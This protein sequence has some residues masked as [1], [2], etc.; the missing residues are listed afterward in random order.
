MEKY[1]CVQKNPNKYI[2]NCEDFNIVQKDGLIFSTNIKKINTSNISITYTSS[3][4]S[5]YKDYPHDELKI[6]FSGYVY[7]LVSFLIWILTFWLNLDYVTYVNNLY[8]STNLYDEKFW[9]LIEKE[10]F[11]DIPQN[12]IIIRSIN[13]THQKQIKMLESKGFIKVLSRHINICNPNNMKKHYKANNRHDFNKL[14]LLLK[15]KS[16]KIH[17][18]KA[19]PDVEHSKH[20]NLDDYV[21]T[22][23]VECYKILYHQKYSEF[24]PDFT[25]NWLKI[26]A[27]CSNT[28]FIWIS[29]ENKI[30]GVIGYYHVNGVLTTP[31]FG[32]DTNFNINSNINSDTNLNYSLYRALSALVHYECKRLN[33]IENRSGGCK[34]FK[35]QR[36]AIGVLEYSMVKIDHIK[37]TNLTNI[38]KKISWKYLNLITNIIDFFYK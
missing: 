33:L 37:N 32:Y 7:C 23:F 14:K 21:L 38:L 26:Y 30:I 18:Y 9:M 6:Y 31:L 1:L 16:F 24:N 12:P 8:L 34:D 13:S 5:H 3:Q 15:N 2:K 11:S 25:I 17:A 29:Y 35:K 20:D 28:G 4:S 22:S 10:N 27:E 19:E 36:G